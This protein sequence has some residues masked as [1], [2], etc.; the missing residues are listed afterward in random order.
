V[1]KLSLVVSL[2]NNN[3]YQQ[4][5]AKAAQET[6]RRLGAD[7]QIIYADNDS[8][9]QSSQLLDFVQSRG[10]RPDGILFEPLTSTGLVRV[11]EAAVNAGIGWGVLNSD[12]DY[13]DRLR[14]FSKAPVFEVTRDHTE[15][16]RIQARQLSA[17]LP[18][19]GN[20]LYVQGPANNSAAMQRTAGM[21]SLK[22]QNIN[23]KL[24][25]SQWT[26]ESA[27]QSVTAWLRLSTSRA[28]TIHAVSC[29]Y[30]GIA[31][32]ARKAFEEA[33]NIADRERWL[34]LPFTGVDGLP[35]EGQ[36][37]VKQ[38]ILAATV[39]APTTT[40][41]GIELLAQALEK[42]GQPQIRTLISLKSYPT[43]EEL[44]RK[45]M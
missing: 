34:K 32:G 45:A 30:D 17:L 36:A 25:R 20:V 19:G 16:G 18:K 44:A 38:G 42:G 24:L 23:L 43:I 33:F 11:A 14:T 7:V 28:E 3:S 1:K 31:M 9:R 26:P 39:V 40:Q 8:V 35:E 10:S 37:W 12:V 22:P 27:Q 41:I 29:Q 2:P 5:Q 15:I 6:A 21:E 4:E 13:L